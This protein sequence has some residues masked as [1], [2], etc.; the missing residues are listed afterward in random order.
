LS[1]GARQDELERIGFGPFFESQLAEL[2]PGLVPAR[3]AIAHGE[4]YVAWTATG[5]AKALIVGRKLATWQTAADRPQVGDW[6]AGALS[7]ELGALL[8]EH[9][10]ERRT[11]LVRQ[12]AA[13]R[14]EL[15]VVA[16]NVDVVGIVTALGEGNDARRDLR[17]IGENRLR[18]Y[19]GAVAESGARPLLIVN[20]SD[21][22]T[23]PTAIASSLAESFPDVPVVVLSGQQGVGIDGLGPW[24]RTGQTVVLVGMSGVGKSTLVN[25]LLGRAAQRVG[26]VRARDARG[27]H[28]TTHRELVV[29]PN[30][31]LLIDT[32]GMR[33]MALGGE[34]DV[35]AGAPPADRRGR[36]RQRH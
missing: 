4:S 11:C 8:I 10:L 34:E 19:L 25:T 5:V 16:A 12:A 15:Q 27:R 35:G 14:P 24:L 22:S 17:V 26:A 9:R 3:I 36:R 31:A 33:E 23:D 29:L 6:V 1:D 32:P 28:T 7:T 13:D 20:K 2:E 21:L 18:R 30:G